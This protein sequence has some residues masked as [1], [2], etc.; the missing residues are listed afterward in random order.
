MTQTA[1]LYANLE[2]RLVT[3]KTLCDGDG[4]CR[5]VCGNMAVDARLAASCLLRPQKGDTVLLAQLEDGRHIVLAVLFR[6]EGERACLRLPPQSDMECAGALT[7]SCAEALEL[8]SG[9]RLGMR[10]ADL[11]VTA[12]NGAL[13]ILNVKSASDV[14]EVC[15][16]ALTTLG[17]TA[18][19]VFRSLTQC[20]GSSRRVVEGD[21]ETRAGNSTL[22]TGGNA[23]VMSKNGLNLAEETARTDAKLIQLG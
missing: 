13:H 1:E 16:R 15:C 17:G 3:G 11:A 20:L 7:V 2:A 9:Q 5:V 8:Q 19:S 10:A 4:A 21:D 23:V 22:M 6:D 18:L 12:K 14:V